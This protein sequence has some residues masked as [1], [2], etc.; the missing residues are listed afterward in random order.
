MRRTHGI[1]T[2]DLLLES[3]CDTAIPLGTARGTGP[4]AT[5]RVEVIPQAAFRVRLGAVHEPVAHAPRPV[6]NLSSA[7]LGSAAWAE[8]PLEAPPQLAPELLI[9]APTE[10]PLR[11]LPEVVRTA[12]AAEPGQPPARTR[13]VSEPTVV[14]LDPGAPTARVARPRAPSPRPV[15]V[16]H[17]R[18]IRERGRAG[19][20]VRGTADLPTVEQ[21]KA[22]RFFHEAVKAMR[23]DDYAAADRHLALALTFAP[24]HP[25]YLLIR[26]KVRHYLDLT[27]K[28]I[29]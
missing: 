17:H 16:M 28:D 23:T 20:P 22:E 24:G 1:P 6:L 3:P 11:P 19:E 26:K 10:V 21:T 9:E 5:T 13:E 12:C 25:R 7:L 8:T 27:T 4:S 2:D 15:A 29:S 14:G 18:Q